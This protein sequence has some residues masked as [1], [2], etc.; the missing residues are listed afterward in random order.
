MPLTG[1]GMGATLSSF[2]QTGGGVLG[3]WGVFFI[4]LIT[5]IRVWPALKKV[6]AE[7][8]ASLRT[9]LLARVESLETRLASLERELAVERALRSDVEHD[10]VNER[11]SF[12]AFIMLAE[13]NPDKVLERLQAIKEERRLHRERMASKR[14][15]RE[16]AIIA[17][18]GQ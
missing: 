8:D 4:A 7:S 15:Q 16:G 11:G 6:Q 2:A 9:A 18:S 5:L 13:A 17:G 12:D 14:G 10:L 1:A 3:I